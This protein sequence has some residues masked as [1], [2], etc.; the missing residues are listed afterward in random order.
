MRF[1]AQDVELHSALG[2]ALRLFG[3]RDHLLPRA[4]ERQLGLAIG[5]G[6]L[7]GDLLRKLCA[8]LAL[9]TAASEP[10]RA[11]SW[12]P[13]HRACLRRP[14][15]RRVLR[16]RPAPRRSRP[17]PASRRR[18]STFGR[19]NWRNA[20]P[21]DAHRLPER[22]AE[23]AAIG[24]RIGGSAG[25]SVPVERREG[26]IDLHGLRLLHFLGGGVERAPRPCQN[27]RGVR[28]RRSGMLT[29]VISAGLAM[30]SKTE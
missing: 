22:I 8:A 1:H 13:S 9:V 15:V 4:V 3:D 29:S 2:L 21:R 28:L 19:W 27:R 25:R 14:L 23:H 12:S 20:C 24:L 16:N 18:P 7:L 6:V 11:W 30:E 17:A 10:R 5:L 26:E